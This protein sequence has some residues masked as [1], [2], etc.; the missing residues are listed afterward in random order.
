MRCTHPVY[1]VFRTVN[2][3]TGDNFVDYRLLAYISMMLAD[4]LL[5]VII[6]KI[7]VVLYE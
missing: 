2:E 1:E 6:S 7:L 5:T 4:Y 3:G